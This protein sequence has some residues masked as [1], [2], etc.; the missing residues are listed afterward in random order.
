MP[1]SVL[2]IMGSCEDATRAERKAWDTSVL[3]RVGAAPRKSL[4]DVTSVRS[5]FSSSFL[6]TLL[7]VLLALSNGRPTPP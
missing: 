4:A 5:A 3:T 7:M 6:R 2:P 1:S